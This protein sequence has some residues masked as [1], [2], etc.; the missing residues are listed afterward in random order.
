MWSLSTNTKFAAI[1]AALWLIWIANY[2]GNLLI[3]HTE[4]VHADDAEMVA[5]TTAPAKEAEPEKPLPVLLAEADAEKGARVAKKCVSCHTFDN[6]GK[7]KV[8]PNLWALMTRTRGQHEGFSYSSAMAD[9]GGTWS[10]EDLDAFIAKPKDFLS[11][12]KMA[13]AG[14]KKATDRAD[15]LAYMRTLH[16]SPP[17]LPQQ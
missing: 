17:P 8:G 11:G 6:G 4:I 2:A 10:Y 15:L 3:P 14:I 16:D 7:N 12:T 9:L 1:V 13:F 5:S